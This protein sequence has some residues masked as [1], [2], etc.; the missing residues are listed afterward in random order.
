VK[1]TP[2]RETPASHNE[3]PLVAVLYSRSIFPI[4]LTVGKRRLSFVV[5]LYY[6]LLLYV[7]LRFPQGWGTPTLKG[8]GCLAEILKKNSEEVPRSCLWAW[9][10]FF[11]PSRGT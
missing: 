10:E 9:L 2:A 8:R 7:L 6:G 5:A 11:S 1:L 3:R 4:P